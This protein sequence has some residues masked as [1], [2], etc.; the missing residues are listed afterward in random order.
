MV[1]SLKLFNPTHA[2]FACECLPPMEDLVV[3]PN[4]EVEFRPDPIQIDEMLQSLG[5]FDRNNVDRT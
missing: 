2:M 1:Q 3:G 4:L 5:L